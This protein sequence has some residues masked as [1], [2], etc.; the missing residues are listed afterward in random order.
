MTWLDLLISLG[1][2]SIGLMLYGAYSA[3]REPKP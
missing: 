3:L 1:V 2:A